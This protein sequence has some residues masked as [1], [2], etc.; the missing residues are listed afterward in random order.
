MAYI[1]MWLKDDSVV[2]GQHS[3]TYSFSPLNKTDSGQYSCQVIVG[4]MNVTSRIVSIIV[5][6]K[7][8]LRVTC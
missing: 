1:Y 6:G 2:S 3:S 8:K 4:T 5:V 7:L